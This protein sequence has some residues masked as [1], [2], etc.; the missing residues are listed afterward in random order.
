MCSNFFCT[1]RYIV[2]QRVYVIYDAIIYGKRPLLRL[3]PL[4]SNNELSAAKV[5]CCVTNR[6]RWLYSAKVATVDYLYI[7]KYVILLYL[8]K[9]LRW[10]HTKCNISTKRPMRAALGIHYKSQLTVSYCISAQV[11]LELLFV[12]FGYFSV[13]C[14]S[15]ADIADSVDII[16]TFW[17]VVCILFCILYYV[18]DFLINKWITLHSY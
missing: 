17:L 18:Y 9:L 4:P 13:S 11:L 10:C 1:L 2:R 7:S 5:H 14:L 6:C 3:R 16:C 8:E 12:K 15:Q